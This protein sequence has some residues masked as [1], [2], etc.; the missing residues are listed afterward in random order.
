MIPY[1]LFWLLNV[2]LL[3]DFNLFFSKVN[4]LFGR[5]FS[6]RTFCQLP[7][8]LFKRKIIV[9]FRSLYYLLTD[10][11]KYIYFYWRIIL[12]LLAK[13]KQNVKKN[14]MFNPLDRHFLKTQSFNNTCWYKLQNISCPFLIYWP[15][16]ILIYF[17]RENIT[18]CE[19][20]GLTRRY[21]KACYS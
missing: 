2:T 18:R 21:D 1:N 16:L 9:Y 17:I 10:P 15:N 11:P 12:F 19:F 5:P 3:Q 6:S 20:T 13:L 8:F 4:F 14:D 7:V